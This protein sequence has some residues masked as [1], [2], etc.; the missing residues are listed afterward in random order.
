M[1]LRDSVRYH[2]YCRKAKKLLDSI[3]SEF[4]FYATFINPMRFFGL[5]NERIIEIKN[6]LNELSIYK[7]LDEN[8]PIKQDEIDKNAEY[9]IQLY[10]Y[11]KYLIND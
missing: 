2:Q 7:A 11:Y 10:N 5:N 4:W 8:S 9:F 1:I 3:D 6:A